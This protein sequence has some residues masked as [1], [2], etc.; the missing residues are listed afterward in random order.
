MIKL[1]AFLTIALFIGG[2][3]YGGYSYF[4]KNQQ[5][6]IM[7]QKNITTY[8]NAI[9][10]TSEAMDR[11]RQETDRIQEINDQLNNKLKKAEEYKDELTKK[12]NEHNLTKLS[13]AKPGLIE[14][15]VND[16]TTKI[17]KELEDITAV[18]PCC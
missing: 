10:S 17:F 16:A 3:V 2:I 6:L 4:Q 14:K 18:P 5:E 1:Y 11:M 15:R 7:L 8:E 9:K 13:T 12:L